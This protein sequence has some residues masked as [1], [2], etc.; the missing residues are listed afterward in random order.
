MRNNT[1]SSVAPEVLRKRNPFTVKAERLRDVK[2]EQPEEG[3][4]IYFPIR[5]FLH[6]TETIGGDL[7][8]LDDIDFVSYRLD[9][10]F[11]QPVRVARSRTNAFELTIWTYGFF[12]VDATIYTTWNQAFV[13]KGVSLEWTVTDEEK[14]VNGSELQW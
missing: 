6:P 10:S 13:I 12:R 7:L 4:L 3:S 11:P 9:P 2:S 5:L 1:I 14:K 8:T